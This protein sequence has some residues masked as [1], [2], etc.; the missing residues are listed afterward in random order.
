MTKQEVKELVVKLAKEILSAFTNTVVDA[1]CTSM[2]QVDI[3]LR[4]NIISHSKKLDVRIDAIQKFAT[5]NSDLLIKALESLQKE[6]SDSEA[7]IGVSI[8][9]VEKK[10]KD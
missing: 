9:K 8:D 3:N 6:Y 1:V 4:K 10:A 7:V 2:Q 5:D